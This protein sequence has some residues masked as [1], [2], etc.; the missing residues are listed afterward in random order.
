MDLPVIGHIGDAVVIVHVHIHER[1]EHA[2]KGGIDP[3]VDRAERILDRIGC[4]VDRLVITDIAGADQGFA[5][6]LLHIPAGAFQPV[7]SAGDQPD[8][9]AV[10]RETTRHRPAHACRGSGDGDDGRAVLLLFHVYLKHTAGRR[11]RNACA[12]IS[13]LTRPS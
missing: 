9:G 2:G 8:A 7:L 10:P 13:R 1:R 6:Q 3:D 11:F 5:A 12:D 4:L